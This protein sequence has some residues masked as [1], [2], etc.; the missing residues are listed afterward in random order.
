MQE[1]WKKQVFEAGSWQMVRGQVGAVCGDL[2]DAYC[3]QHGE[4]LM[5]DGRLL[6]SHTMAPSDVEKHLI[7]GPSS[8]GGEIIKKN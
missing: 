2:T 4:V 1:A 6:D 8:G 5:V 7:Q 3:G